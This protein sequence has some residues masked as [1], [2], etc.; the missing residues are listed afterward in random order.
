LTQNLKTGFDQLRTD[1]LA[2]MFRDYG[3]GPKAHA[4]YL[5]GLGLDCDGGKKDMA[6]NLAVQNRNQRYG[7][8]THSPEL[9]NKVGLDGLG[10]RF[11]VYGTHCGDIIG[12]FWTYSYHASFDIK[13]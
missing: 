5:S 13:T 12:L 2:L 8:H 4:S 1:P 9:V 3:H 11:L 10:K 6:Y 7:I